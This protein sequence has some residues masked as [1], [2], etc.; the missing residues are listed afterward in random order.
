VHLFVAAQ[1]DGLLGILPEAVK[2]KLRKPLFEILHP[3]VVEI[4]LLLCNLGRLVMLLLFDLS[5]QQRKELL[6]GL[7]PKFRYNVFQRPVVGILPWPVQR[8]L[9]G[10][11]SREEQPDSPRGFS[12]QKA[13]GVGEETCSMPSTME[14]DVE[15]SEASFDSGC[16][17]SKSF[18][19]VM[20]LF[21]SVEEAARGPQ[22]RGSAAL[23]WILTEKVAGTAAGTAASA[24]K[25]GGRATVES[26]RAMA[27]SAS[28][29]VS[30]FGD[31][32][33]EV[34]ASERTQV[35]AV[36]AVGGAVA[37]GAGSGAT[38][39][40]SG[41]VIG[42]VLGVAPALFTFG[43]SIPV[44]A[45]IGAGTGLCVG[46]TVGGAAGGIG[47]GAAG[48]RLYQRR[49]EAAAATLCVADGTA[50]SDASSP[51]ASDVDSTALGLQ[52]RAPAKYLW[53]ATTMLKTVQ[54]LGG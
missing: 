9:L 31:G 50:D 19:E 43:L 36:S 11:P 48:F 25:R 28:A 6:E 12:T 17:R 45:A 23:Q 51:T 35:M 52:C 27:S 15:P 4:T 7:D 46:A 3:V 16:R 32:V 44:G 14:T 42:A 2:L 49:A 5:E 37:L 21:K 20:S 30:E 39:L 54:K 13:K 40:V 33:R 22:Q 8:V 1:G 34:M 18:D 10:R 41:G 47:G 38:G 24:L 53:G 29:Q 26:A